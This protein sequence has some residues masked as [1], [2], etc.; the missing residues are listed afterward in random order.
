MYFLNS[1]VFLLIVKS[2]AF[3]YFTLFKTLLCVW[4]L[5]WNR[6]WIEL[7]MY[8]SRR[9]QEGSS[10]TLMLLYAV[11]NVLGVRPKLFPR[12]AIH[13]MCC[14]YP[15]WSALLKGTTASS[16]HGTSLYFLHHYPL[17]A[18]IK[19]D[20]DYRKL[21]DFFKKENWF[22]LVF[23]NIMKYNYQTLSLIVGH[24]ITNIFYHFY[25]D[26][27]I[28]VDALRWTP[29]FWIQTFSVSAFNWELYKH[30]GRLVLYCDL[31]IHGS[32]NIMG[33]VDLPVF[34]S[35][36]VACTGQTFFPLGQQQHICWKTDNGVPH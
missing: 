23:K 32:R 35:C 12:E 26:G 2:C 21:T 17:S 27:C 34:S 4:C 5:I 1:Y 13:A 22:L 11:S 7:L 15:G 20:D 36:S 18:F 25:I 3:V 14:W 16:P 31:T 33:L 8:S 9:P 10:V 30:Y 6:S 29:T 28:Y 19:D 24:D